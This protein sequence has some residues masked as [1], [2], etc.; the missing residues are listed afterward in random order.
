[1]LDEGDLCEFWSSDVRAVGWLWEIAAGGWLDL[2]RS[3]PTFIAGMNDRCREF[4]V[5]GCDA[6][7]SVISRSEPSLHE[8]AA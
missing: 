5:L 7:V 2:E 6:C 4:L 3:R 1:V 8:V